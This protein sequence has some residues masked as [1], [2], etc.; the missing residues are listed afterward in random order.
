[1]TKIKTTTVGSYSPIDWLAALPSEQAILDATAVVFH[2]Q[3]RCGVAASTCPPTGNYT[4]SM[5][6]I[7]I[8]TG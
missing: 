1:M 7:Q 2:T 8:P 5:L 6:I 3:Q 4:V